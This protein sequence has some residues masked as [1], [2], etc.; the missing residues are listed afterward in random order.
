MNI[1]I[2]DAGNSIIKGKIVRRENGEVAY[3]H[4]LKT[5]TEAEYAAILTRAGR[6]GPPPDYLRINGQPYVVGESA[7]R[8]TA[9]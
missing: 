8:H 5:L 1:L 9:P 2:L 7:E 6:S 4:A 3:P